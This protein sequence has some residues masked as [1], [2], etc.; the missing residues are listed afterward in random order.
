MLKVLEIRYLV[1][2]KNLQLES[3]PRPLYLSKAH[4]VTS[5]Q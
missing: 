5:E 3:R 4:F 1:T 2:C